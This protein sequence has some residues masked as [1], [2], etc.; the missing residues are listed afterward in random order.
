MSYYTVYLQNLTIERNW[1]K[2]TQ[3]FSVL[4]LSV[5]FKCT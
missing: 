5:L 3:D 1:L 2:N 4:F